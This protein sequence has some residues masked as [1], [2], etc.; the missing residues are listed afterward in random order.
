MNAYFAWF[1][2]PGTFVLTVLLSLTALL[3]AVIRRQSYAWVCFAAMLMSSV[4]DL[5]MTGF[6]DIGTLVPNSFIFG[7]GAFAISHIIYLCAYRILIRRRGYRTKNAGMYAA[8]VFALGCLLYFTY[9]CA[10]RGDFSMYPVC[11][12]YLAVIAANCATIFSYSHSRARDG[13]PYM[14][15]AAVGAL[16]FMLSDFFI[17]LGT[18]A[19]INDLD[20]LIWWLYPIGQIL[21]L[22]FAV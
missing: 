12:I 5:F 16:S 22:L 1:G 21:M 10:V 14:L 17:G 15:L 20:F 7:A 13:H 4:G 18:L 8:I 11:M 3:L 6:G 19:G 2:L 9:V